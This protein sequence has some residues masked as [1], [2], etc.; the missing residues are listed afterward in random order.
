MADTSIKLS[1]TYDSIEAYR[2]LEEMRDMSED[3]EDIKTE[4]EA[5]ASAATAAVATANAAVTNATTAANNAS[6]YAGNANTSAS[7]A[8]GY[9]SNASTSATNAATSETNA[10]N[11]ASAA[12]MSESNAATSETNASDSATAAAASAAE[13]EAA[14]DDY[15]PLSGGTMTGVTS[16]SLNNAIARSSNDDFILISGGASWSNG[17][18]I[19]LC[20]KDRQSDAGSFTLRAADGSNSTQLFGNPDGTL[21]W[22]GQPLLPIGVVQ[23]F[24]GTTIPAGWLLCDG[25]AV[26]RTTYA[27]LFAVIG[28][29]YGS[30]DGSTTFNVPN[31][32]DKFVEGSATSGTKKSAGLPNITGSFMLTTGV[33][34]GRQYALNPLNQSGA[35]KRGTST[36]PIGDFAPSSTGTTYNATDFDA[37]LSNSIYSDDVTTVQP[38]ALTMQYIIKY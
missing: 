21:T 9:A 12:A 4:A 16:Y 24:A 36:G 30:G 15:L 18:Y 7:D 35:F 8:A 29:T 17:A 5:A 25:S 20:G 32:V 27:N 10:S 34:G 14:L 31:L 11:S 22:G 23:A 33:T 19:A 2:I 3:Y 13:V 6:T 26:S 1:G 28:T 38:P 37:S